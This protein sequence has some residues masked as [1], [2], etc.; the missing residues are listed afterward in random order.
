MIQ[1]AEDV[2]PKAGINI[3]LDELLKAMNKGSKLVYD[4]STEK[5]YTFNDDVERIECLD[6][7]RGISVAAEWIVSYIPEVFLDTDK[8]GNVK[9][10]D[11]CYKLLIIGICIKD[12]KTDILEIFKN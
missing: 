3:T 9:K 10:A 12:F 1:V 6:L 7:S 4:N 5:L 8:G 11:C 2:L